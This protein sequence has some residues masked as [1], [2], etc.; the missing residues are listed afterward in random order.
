MSFKHSCL[1]SIGLLIISVGL[2]KEAHARNISGLEIS[3]ASTH[4]ALNE[5]N[6]IPLEFTVKVNGDP[7]T[8]AGL[9]AVLDP[10]VGST[11]IAST[12]QPNTFTVSYTPPL[13][14]AVDVNVVVE[15]LVIEQSTGKSASALISLT[16]NLAGAVC[17]ID[18][19]NPEPRGSCALNALRCASN[20]RCV[21]AR[22]HIR[23][24][25]WCD[26]LDHCDVKRGELAYRCDT[27]NH[28]CVGAS[29]GVS[30][31]DKDVN[32]VADLG[33]LVDTIPRDMRC[34]RALICK[35]DEQAT[36]ECVSD[37]GMEIGDQIGLGKSTDDIRDQ[38]RQLVNIALG[39]LG[40]AGVVIVIYGGA[41]W[42][43]AMGNDEKVEKGKKT[44][45]SGVVG[46]L[47]IGVAWTI[48]SYVVNISHDL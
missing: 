20:S 28:F 48:V 35:L 17:L 15:M 25:T 2:V 23:I 32:Q 27:V 36:G 31:G 29:K 34:D 26:E 43:S 11:T 39:F 18:Q 42:M 7:V 9:R 33:Y 12:G 22:E 40:I 24:G 5:T 3:P 4:A 41:L 45:I 8:V 16:Y 37:Q 6:A 47:I 10:A 14:G 30:C 38:I 13:L 21:A 46:L 44:I 19:F 1:I